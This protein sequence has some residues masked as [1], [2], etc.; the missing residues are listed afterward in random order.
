MTSRRFRVRWTEEAVADLE[1]LVRYAATADSPLAAGRLVAT[2]EGKAESLRSVPLRGRVVAELA[3][4][5]IRTWRE[6]IV[7]PYRIMYRIAGDTIFVLAVLDGR[8]DLRDVL[9]ERLLRTE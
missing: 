4:F 7:K 3:Y 9:L 8:R 2:L 6:L 5:A 1:D